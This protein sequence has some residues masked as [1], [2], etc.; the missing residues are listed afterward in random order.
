[1]TKQEEKS[2]K[3]TENLELYI[4]PTWGAAPVQPIATKIGNSLHMTGVFIRSKFG[5]VWYSSFGYE[6]L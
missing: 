1:L 3:K 6:E 4:S 5:I 2:K